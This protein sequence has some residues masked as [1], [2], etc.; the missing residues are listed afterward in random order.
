MDSVRTELYCTYNEEVRYAFEIILS[1]WIY[2]MVLKNLYAM[3]QHQVKDGN[4]MKV[5]DSGRATRCLS[6]G[7]KV[8]CEFDR[9][10]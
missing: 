4:F 8:E 2:M 10:D 9:S 1:A 7:K 5:S 6:E 3:L